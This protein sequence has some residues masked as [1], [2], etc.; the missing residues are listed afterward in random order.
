ML[1]SNGKLTVYAS[2]R[3]HMKRLK[4][5][6]SA[7]AKVADSLQLDTELSPKRKLLSIYVYY[8]SDSGDEIPVYCDWG[9][10][11]KEDDIYQA[12]RNMM[13]VLSFHP[14]H[15]QLRMMRKEICIS[16]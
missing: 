10:S 14:Q 1:E 11:W 3:P 7:V 8:K 5:V 12:I 6:G 16:A 4:I 13:F 15:S 2:N 9:K